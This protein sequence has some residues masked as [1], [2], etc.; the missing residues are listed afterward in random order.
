M[1][2]KQIETQILGWINHQ[3]N[4][5]AFKVNTVGVYDSKKGVYRRNLNPFVMRGTAD[6]IGICRGI[7][8]AIEVKTPTTIKRFRNNPTQADRLQQ[9]FLMRVEQK[10]GI[11]A[12]VC[13]LDEVIELL[14]RHI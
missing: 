3:T 4:C 11:A 12:C 10:G 13:S 1:T 8:L 7:F 2:E 6:I 5:F 9:L 14:K